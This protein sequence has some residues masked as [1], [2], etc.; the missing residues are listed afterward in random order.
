MMSICKPELPKYLS[1]G[2][3]TLVHSAI[4]MYL[5]NIYNDLSTL[6][7]M[8]LQTHSVAEINQTYLLM[9]G[10]WAILFTIL[11]VLTYRRRVQFVDISNRI[12]TRM[13]IVLFG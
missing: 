12:A 10:K 5:P 6:M 11:G 9:G 3:I 4:F 13:R 7:E 1:N 2:A 8:T